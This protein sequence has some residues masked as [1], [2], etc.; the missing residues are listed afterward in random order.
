[1][2]SKVGTDR[3]DGSFT[4]KDGAIKDAEIEIVFDALRSSNTLEI[5]YDAG[6]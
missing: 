2:S 4:F 1:M 6:T 5:T 3:N